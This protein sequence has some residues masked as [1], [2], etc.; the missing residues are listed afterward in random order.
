MMNLT[1][2][3]SGFDIVS[4]PQTMRDKVPTSNFFLQQSYQR[5]SVAIR[6]NV[7]SKLLAVTNS[8]MDQEIKLSG[9]KDMAAAF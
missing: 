6:N 3:G 8:R 7:V 1:G 5:N 9:A 2:D 4:M